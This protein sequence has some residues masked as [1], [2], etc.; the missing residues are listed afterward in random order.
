MP[1]ILATDQGIL[2]FYGFDWNGERMWS[3]ILTS[4]KED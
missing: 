4:A 2:D 1:V 3:S